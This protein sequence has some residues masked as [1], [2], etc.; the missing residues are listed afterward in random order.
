MAQYDIP[1]MTD[2]ERAKFHADRAA[3]N[4]T[5]EQEKEE[6][7]GVARLLEPEEASRAQAVIRDIDDMYIDSVYGKPSAP[8]PAQPTASAAPQLPENGKTLL[9]A[10][11]KT[12]RTRYGGSVRVVDQATGAVS[13]EDLQGNKVAAP[14]SVQMMEAAN[15]GL[16]PNQGTAASWDDAIR[17]QQAGKI[18]RAEA[19]AR[20]AVN[21]NMS[22]REQ[23]KTL[24]AK[25]TAMT[26]DQIGAAMADLRENLKLA[27]ERGAKAKTDGEASPLLDESDG[28][29]I[30]KA[31]DGNFY[32][33]G[34]VRPEA[35]EGFNS[36]FAKFGGKDRMERIVASQRVDMYGNPIGDPTFAAIYRRNGILNEQGDGVYPKK[37]S[38]GEAMR[39]VVKAQVDLGKL[40]EREAQTYAVNQFGANPYGWDIPVTQREKFDAEQANRAAERDAK[41]SSAKIAADARVAAAAARTAVAKN[42]RISDKDLAALFNAAGNLNGVPNEE[43]QAM[44]ELVKKGIEQRQQDLTAGGDAVSQDPASSEDNSKVKIPTVKNGTLLMPDGKVLRRGEVWTDKKKQKWEWIGPGPKDFKKA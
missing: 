27:Q 8:A 40:T 37:L 11:G 3:M 13:W 1:D 15:A 33:R 36:E 14:K 16:S 39:S 28:G 22:A 5:P 12:G 25:Q 42:E 31:K 9:S 35:L 34:I 29:K 17:Q 32:V 44:L 23:A 26:G 30:Y 24:A 7:L 41:V 18:A 43:R 10:D 21:A 2:E 4:L 20:A 19:Y 38:L 6:A